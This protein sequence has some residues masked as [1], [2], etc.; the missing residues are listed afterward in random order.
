MYIKLGTIKANRYYDDPNDFIILSE[1]PSS[2]MSFE[3]P[4]RVR[5]L[6][7]LNIWFGKTYPEYQYLRELVESGITLYLYKPASLDTI[8]T[9]EYTDQYIENDIPF[10]SIEYI[11]KYVQGEEKVRYHSNDGTWLY[12]GGSWINLSDLISSSESQD[13]YNRDTLLLSEDAV[14]CHPNYINE[15]IEE[16]K[17]YRVLEAP[18]KLLDI[19]YSDSSGVYVSKIT[20][21]GED[22]KINEYLGLQKE[23]G[24]WI[25]YFY[26]GFDRIR[27]T[28]GQNVQYQKVEDFH[29]LVEKISEDYDL[30]REI[31][32]NEY[33]L[34]SDTRRDLISMNTFSSVSVEWEEEEENRLIASNILESECGYVSWWS[35]TIGRDKNDYDLDESRIKISIEDVGVDGYMIRISRYGYSEYYL[36]HL[37]GTVDEEGILD[38]ISKESKLVRCEITKEIEKLPEGEFYLSGATVEEPTAEWYRKS[39]DLLVGDTLEDSVVPDFF[40]IPDLSLYGEREDEQLF[41]PYATAGNFQ[42]LISETTEEDYKKNYLDDKEN[43]LLYFYGGIKYKYQ[44]RPAYYIYLK[45]LLE[46]NT[47]GYQTKDII[48]N[49]GNNPYIDQEELEMYK[50]NYLVSNNQVYYYNKYQ[51]GE[52]YITSGLMRFIMGKVYREIQ[53]RRWEIIGQK[54]NVL[55]EKKINEIVQSVAI[56]ENVKSI[57]I[58]SYLPYPE[59]ESLDVEVDIWTRELLQN[60]V[61]LDITINYKKYGN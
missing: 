45:S 9:T 21:T 57:E 39:M 41:L 48:Y 31:S 18:E 55:I 16:D 24:D 20:W 6:D 51:N 4:I 2:S 3:S 32:E 15:Y 12:Y 40:M 34:Y 37:Q 50:C 1:V 10:P 36:G 5:S 46:N 27:N 17:R 56:F 22:L 38:R 42:Y 49:S 35:K 19:S 44:D 13:T 28:I 7:E 33:L 26:D 53:K 11:E 59:L 54:F 61:T 25:I 14:F 8:D 60:N 47:H 43:R 58:I 29:D 23:T 30:V 52:D